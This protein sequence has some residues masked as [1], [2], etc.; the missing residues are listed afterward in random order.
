MGFFV[1]KTIKRFCN[2]YNK[3][4]FILDDVF[5]AFLSGEALIS[6]S[7]SETEGVLRNSAFMKENINLLIIA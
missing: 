3:F 5:K 6:R 7:R 4:C 1:T 2:W